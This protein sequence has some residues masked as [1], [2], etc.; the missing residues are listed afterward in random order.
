METKDISLSIAFEYLR[1]KNK[2]ATAF[3]SSLAYACVAI[4]VA[5]L[6]IVSSVMNGFEK[7][8]R[9]RILNVI[10][11]A[12]IMGVVPISNWN[13]V[14]K[15]LKEHPKVIGVS[16]FV[17]SQMLIG[18]SEE[19]YGSNLVGIVPDSEKNVSVVSNFIIKGSYDSL[20]EQADNIILGELLARKLNLD[21]GNQVSLML[22]DTKA[23]FAGYFPKIKNFRVTGIFRVGAP[24]IDEGVAYVNI[25]KAANLL[26]IKDQ[27]QGFRIKFDDLFEANYL[28]WEVLMDVEDQT[29]QILISEK[30]DSNIWTFI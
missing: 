28:S 18:S 30:L 12:S 13:D 6:I 14:Y 22:P 26:S 17:Q 15:S 9:D 4:G 1:S 5:V 8:L 20:N 29:D 11:H 21:V 16:P 10:P 27:V 23:S 25:S 19:V 3:V 24:D 7:E 2:G